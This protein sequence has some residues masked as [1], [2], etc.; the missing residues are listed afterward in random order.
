[1][2]R[3]DRREQ[4]GASPVSALIYG[5]TA[6]VILLAVLVA[7]LTDATRGIVVAMTGSFAVAALLAYRTTRMCLRRSRRSDPPDIP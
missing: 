1:M 5:A 6:D 2:T 3:T 7:I 4:R